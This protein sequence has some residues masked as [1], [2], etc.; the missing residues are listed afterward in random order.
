MYRT[1]A[2]RAALYWQR[3][4][5][6]FGEANWLKPF[7]VETGGAM[8]EEDLEL[9]KAGWLIWLPKGKSKGRVVLINHGRHLLYFGTARFRVGFFLLTVCTDEE[10]QR[11]GITFI[12]CLQTDTSVRYPPPTNANLR[13]ASDMWQCTFEAMP[14]KVDQILLL[15]SKTNKKGDTLFHL[16]LKH[17]GRVIAKLIGLSST[18]AVEVDS[19][20]QAHET[21]KHYGIPRAC[22]PTTHGGTWTHDRVMEWTEYAF[23]NKIKA[24]SQQDENQDDSVAHDEDFSVNQVSV[25]STEQSGR[26]RNRK[27][28]AKRCRI[29]YS[30]RKQRENEIQEDAARLRAEHDTLLTEHMRL[31]ALVQQALD[32]IAHAPIQQHTPVQIHCRSEAIFE[33]TATPDSTPNHNW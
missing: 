10:A 11:N 21:L 17:R 18:Q 31:Q 14:V 3:R 23:A 26:K 27:T 9:L 29:A 32:T 2:R 19:V 8:E 1:A 6:I 25:S 22:L 4:R 7:I 24:S 30:K 12:R 28:N 33:S 15:E 20:S 16:F 13:L 5:Q